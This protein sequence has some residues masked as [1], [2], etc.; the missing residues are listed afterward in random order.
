MKHFQLLIVLSLLG[1]LTACQEQPR[2]SEYYRANLEE[3]R[4][5][6]QKCQQ[7][8]QAGKE[9]KYWLKTA[10]LRMTC[11]CVKPMQVLLLLLKTVSKV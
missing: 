4:K 8:R 9:P 5:D 10:V 3:A 11:C 6:E 2:S 1:S 7:M